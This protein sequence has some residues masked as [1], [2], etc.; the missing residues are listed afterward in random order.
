[1]KVTRNTPEHLIVG[2]NPIWVAVLTGGLAFLFTAIGVGLIMAGEWFG[3]MF[4]IGT[5]VGLLTM[6]VFVRRVQL[7]FDRQAGTLTIQR[8][9]LNRAKQVVHPLEEVKGAE[10][11]GNGN[12]LRVALVL[13]GQSAGRHPITQAYSNVGD[14]HGVAKAI[15]DWLEAARASKAV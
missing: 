4:F 6:Y 3:A 5:F 14:H 11:E 12:M 7:I 13:T 10:L 15:N 2:E 8:K 9:N 1:M